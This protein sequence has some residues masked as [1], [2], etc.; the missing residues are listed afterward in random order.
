MKLIANIFELTEKFLLAL[1]G[2]GFG[3]FSLKREVKLAG[4][5]L[6][7]PPKIIFDVGA[8]RGLYTLA[9]IKKF[10]KAEI[11]MF[12]P[13]SKNYDILTDNFKSYQKVSIYNTAL[14]K[15]SQMQK[16]YFD[17]P[18]SGIAS[19]SQRDLTHTNTNMS[20]SENV[21]VIR[22]DEFMSEIGLSFKEIDLIKLDVEGH[23]LEVIEGMGCW[24][25]KCKLIQ[26]EF[27]GAN[28]DTRTIFKDFYHLFLNNDFELF[29]ISPFGLIK[30]YKYTEFLEH[31]RTTNYLAR[32]KKFIDN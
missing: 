4:N 13:S 23:E 29:R 18:G 32:N 6:P 11:I 25:R 21:T 8:N 16:L 30:V 1:S 15:N 27:G 2:K 5:L 28:L 22:F 12:E 7:C 19:L 20:Q 3:S 9:C 10:P 31:Y 24:L 17:F 14:G 26:F